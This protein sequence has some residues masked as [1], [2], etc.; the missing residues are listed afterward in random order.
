MLF[1]YTEYLKDSKSFGYYRRNS[2]ILERRVAI[3]KNLPALKISKSN[4]SKQ[5]KNDGV[6]IF[7]EYILC[8]NG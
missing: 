1:S 7:R 2:Q 6:P 4:F 5:Q 8:V 3:L